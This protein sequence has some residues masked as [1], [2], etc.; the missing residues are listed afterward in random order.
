MRCDL[1]K[2]GCVGSL[3]LFRGLP[4]TDIQDIQRLIAHRS[5][6]KGETVVREGEQLTGIYI[7][8]SGQAKAYAQSKTG[9]EQVLRLLQVGDFYGEL[10]L[11]SVMEAPSTVQ[12]LTDL[13]LCTISS[14]ALKSYLL[15]HPT[16]ALSILGALSA[17]LRRA[18]QLS[19][20]LGLLDSR[21][22][23]AALLLN[24]NERQGRSTDHGSSIHLHLNRNELASMIGLR[25]ET[26]SR[27]LTEFRQA[28]W[29]ETEGHKL[30]YILNEPALQ[31]LARL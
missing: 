26:L 13:R 20:Q 23:V 5:F 6:T 24:L 11:I 15:S 12:A 16:A 4:L 10:S 21:Q 25:Q 30:L 22:R 18:E 14:E 3:P 9:G 19:E 2:R 17:R 7:V 27:C 28:G 31:E 1:C 8:E 29:I